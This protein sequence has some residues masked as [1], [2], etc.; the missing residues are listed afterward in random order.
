MMN[1]SDLV[2]SKEAVLVFGSLNAKEEDR[3]HDRANIEPVQVFVDGEVRQIPYFND[4]GD[5]GVSSMAM[6]MVNGSEPELYLTT[7]ADLVRL[8]LIGSAEIAHFDIPSL[9]DVHEMTIINSTLWLA[10]TG[11]DE[12]V[13]F[14]LREEKVSSRIK[15]E[16]FRLKTSAT[17]RAATQD[18]GSYEEVDHFHCNQVFEG[19]DGKLYALVHHATGRQLI[20]RIAKKLIK[21]QGDGGV[22]DLQSG[23]GIQLW[24]KAPHTVRI[25]NGEYW[26]FD[27]GNKTMNIYDAE[28]NLKRRVATAGWGRGAGL[29]NDMELFYAGMSEKRKRYQQ[30]GDDSGGN[31]VQVFRTSDGE[32]VGQLPISSGIEQIN[33]IYIIPRTQAL[34]LLA[35]QYSNVEPVSDY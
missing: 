2:S 33:N 3:Y 1:V 9:R 18:S 35:L 6:A 19:I 31:I 8:R 11:Y 34:A 15:L 30:P 21:K 7:G 16:K 32:C 27:S 4:W 17:D 20:T 12:A 26:V 25:V 24:L 13:G 14:D 29:S 23:R 22:V 28:W 5:L 10:N